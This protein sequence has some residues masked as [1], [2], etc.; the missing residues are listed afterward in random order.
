MTELEQCIGDFFRQEA[1]VPSDIDLLITGKNGDQKWDEVYARLSNTVFSGMEQIHFKHLC[2]E[3][4]TAMA[5]ALWTA[6]H[7][8]KDGVVPDVFALNTAADRPVRRILIYN[9][10]NFIHHSLLLVSAC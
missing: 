10:S 7:I 5:F 9:H 4:P 1:I 3:Y 2:G 6:A 8:I